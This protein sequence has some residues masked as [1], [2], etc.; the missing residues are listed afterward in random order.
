MKSYFYLPLLLFTHLT[1]VPEKIPQQQLGS[2][3]EGGGAS[4]E[5]H[6]PHLHGRLPASSRPEL[7]DGRSFT[8]DE[9]RVIPNS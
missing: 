5:S 3:G 9:N 7:G 2:E 1:P 8:F 6:H 4:G